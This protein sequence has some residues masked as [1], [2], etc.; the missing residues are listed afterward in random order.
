MCFFCLI[1]GKCLEARGKIHETHEIILQTVSV[2]V[3]QNPFDC[4]YTRFPLNFMLDLVGK[5]LSGDV[6]AVERA[7]ILYNLCWFSLKTYC[8]KDNR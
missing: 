5:E 8:S 3:S 1:S 2:L 7:A 6:F 4:T